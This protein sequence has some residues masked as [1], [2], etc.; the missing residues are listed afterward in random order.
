MADPHNQR[1]QD[2]GDAAAQ[3]VRNAAAHKRADL[4]RKV[5]QLDDGYFQRAGHK[6]A[7]AEAVR[8]ASQFGGQTLAKLLVWLIRKVAGKDVRCPVRTEI[9]Q[10][11]GTDAEDN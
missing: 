11:T 7:H 8:F 10:F 1:P 4:T 6:I 9:L 5:A 3:Q 2:K